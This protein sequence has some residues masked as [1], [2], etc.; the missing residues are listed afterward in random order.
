MALVRTMG[1]LLGLCQRRAD[2]EG[3]D[4]VDDDE[5][6][7]LI[8]E[9]YGEMHAAVS[10][11]GARYFETEADITANGSAVYALPEA[12]LSTVGVDYVVDSTGHRRELDELMVQE[13]TLF[14]GE[15]GPAWLWSFTGTNIALYPKPS[16]GTYKH[17]YVPQPTDYSSVGNGT[18]I[19]LI[20]IHGLKFLV[21][22]VAS[23][24]MSKGD[25]NQQRAL[26]ERERALSDL[27]SWA[28]Q[29][30]LTMPKRRVVTEE[31]LPRGRISP[32][33]WR[34]R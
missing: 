24:A 27:V 25:D 8:S 29:R 4:H 21:W 23:I 10:D 2:K 1:Q 7:E 34:W 32:A 13:R 19:D 6:K 28:V 14:A 9:V 18:E 17:I 22:G 16:S 12:H 5:W 30:A 11:T 3:D 15:T 26:A 20:N 31:D 33:D